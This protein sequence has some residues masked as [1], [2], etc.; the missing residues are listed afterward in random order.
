MGPSGFIH[1][2]YVNQSVNLSEACAYLDLCL[3]LSS[4]NF[5]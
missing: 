1:N 4:V 5:T 2:E 3:H